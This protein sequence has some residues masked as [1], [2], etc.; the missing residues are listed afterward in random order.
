MTSRKTHAGDGALQVTAAGLH[1]RPYASDEPGP[2]RCVGATVRRHLRPRPLHGRRALGQK[3]QHHRRVAAQGAARADACDARTRHH[4]GGAA[5][6][7]R[8]RVP[9]LQHDRPRAHFRV[10]GAAADHAA[11]V[12]VGA[13]RGG[14]AD[15]ARP[16]KRWRSAMGRGGARDGRALASASARAWDGGGMGRERALNGNE[17]S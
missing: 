6:R 7:R 5:D 17:K 16:V 2:E 10:L 3:R 9:R 4:G 11:T 12:S 13:R 14:L 1:A 8:L 15:A